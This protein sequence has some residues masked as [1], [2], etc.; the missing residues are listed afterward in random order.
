MAIVSPIDGEAGKV[1]VITPEVVLTKYPSQ[2]TALKAAVLTACQLIASKE[3]EAPRATAVPLIV[4]VEFCSLALATLPANLA[5]V[6]VPSAI[7]A[8]T[9]ELS[10]SA[11]ESIFDIAI[12]L[13]F[14]P[15]IY[16]ITLLKFVS[17]YN[18]S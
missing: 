11:F 12:T 17:Y 14:F 6:I 16:T 2:A 3:A 9:T 7:S 13:N 5:L 15:Y 4:T 1:T 8:S 18:D 10:V